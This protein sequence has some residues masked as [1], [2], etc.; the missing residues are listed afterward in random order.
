MAE[1]KYSTSWKGSGRPGKQRK[2]IFEAPLHLQSRKFHVHL[3][4]E[5]RKK[6]GFRHLQLR[7]EDKVKVLRGKFAKKEGKVERVDLKREKVYLTGIEMIK[8]D[9]TKRPFPLLPSHLMI[10]ELSLS[11]KKRRRKLESKSKPESKL[12]QNK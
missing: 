12:K 3:S 10:I 4:P 9:G 7:R 11:D 5:L 1:K 8:K 6:Y 2:F